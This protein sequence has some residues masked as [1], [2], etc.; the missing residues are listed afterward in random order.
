MQLKNLALIAV[1]LAV[2]KNSKY[3]FG[4]LLNKYNQLSTLKRMTNHFATLLLTASYLG[5]AVN[6]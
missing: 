4:G 5:I 6:A 2:N 3:K 1:N